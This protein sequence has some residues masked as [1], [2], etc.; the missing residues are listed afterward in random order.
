ME[1]IFSAIATSFIGGIFSMLSI[2][3]TNHLQKT[4]SNPGPYIASENTLTSLVMHSND[5]NVR[6][7]RYRRLFW[8]T[9]V[10]AVTIWLSPIFAFAMGYII[11]DYIQLFLVIPVY[12]VQTNYLVLYYYEVFKLEKAPRSF[13]WF[14]ILALL[15]GAIGTIFF[16]L[17]I[18]YAWHNKTKGK[19]VAL[20]IA[21]KLK[22]KNFD[23]HVIE[24]IT[25]LSQKEISDLPASALK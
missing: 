14:G 15:F 24:E 8:L 4:Q 9:V 5:V 16:A 23:E 25:G 11:E 21:R 1:Q 3:Y 22:E 17:L 2:W 18:A 7:R 6:L 12:V 19:I 13:Y 10:I 20:K